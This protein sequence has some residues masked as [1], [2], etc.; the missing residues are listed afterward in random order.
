MEPQARGF[1]VVV[2]SEI[3][4]DDVPQAF[5]DVA[6]QAVKDQARTGIKNG[7][8]L[9]DFRCRLTGG[10]SSPADSTEAA[11]R[12][13]ASIAFRKAAET[14]GIVSLQPIMKLEIETP[15]AH[16][17]DVI[18]DISSRRGHVVE[19]KSDGIVAHVTAHVPMAKLFR[20]ATDLRSLT[21]GR[22]VASIE[23]SHFEEV[24]GN[25]NE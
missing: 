11:F 7:H 23:T 12:A 21:K 1:G 8:A 19:M 10:A 13:A 6:V 18:G 22:A 3:S 24:S 16:T 17:G 4:T 9:I 2:E 15:E 25:I 20:Y 5:I 14:A